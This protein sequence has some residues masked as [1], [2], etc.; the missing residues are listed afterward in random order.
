[1]PTAILPL[2]I[3]ENNA[4]RLF[5][6]AAGFLRANWSHHLRRIDETRALF[7]Q[8]QRALQRYGWSRILV[9]QTAML[10]FSQAE[11]AW[12]STE[13]LPQAVQENDYRHGAVVLSPDVFVRL[14]TA[15]ITTSVQGLPLTYRSFDNDAAAASWL[16]Q[17]PVAPQRNQ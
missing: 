7:N 10:P 12:I 5:T 6:D 1:M 9:N 13:W 11:Q 15:S 8:M 3:F 17:Q 16:V 14:A 2:L 4:G